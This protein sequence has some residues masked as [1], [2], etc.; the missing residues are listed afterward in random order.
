MPESS[1]TEVTDQN[2]LDLRQRAQLLEIAIQVQVS[3]DKPYM[4]LLFKDP[5]Q[6]FSAIPVA[7]ALHTNREKQEKCNPLSST[8]WTSMTGLFVRC[9][10]L[11]FSRYLCRDETMPLSADCNQQPHG[12]Q[13]GAKDKDTIP[14]GW[15]GVNKHK[16]IK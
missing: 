16:T 1:V 10:D 6:F 8:T 2:D 13:S 15:V 11:S 14:G 4:R 12:I 5:N 3:L 9:L 7:G